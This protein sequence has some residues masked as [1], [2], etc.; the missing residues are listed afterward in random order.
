MSGNF[1]SKADLNEVEGDVFELPKKSWSLLLFPLQPFPAPVAVPW[2]RVARIQ[3]VPVPTSRVF[4]TQH[5]SAPL[6]VLRVGVA[7]VL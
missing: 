6:L 2:V 5:S 7:G 3:P 4:Q 1:L